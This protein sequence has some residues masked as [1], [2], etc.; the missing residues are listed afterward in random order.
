ML[1]RSGFV[2]TNYGTVLRD[3]VGIMESVAQAMGFG[4]AKTKR[5]REA[6]YMARFYETKGMKKQKQMSAQITNAFRDILIGNKNNDSELSMGGQQKVNELTRELY[7]WNS[8]VDP[9]DAIF[10][11]INR[12]WDAAMKS[13][14]QVVRDLSLSPQTQK[15]MQK[16]REMYDF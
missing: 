7:K 9:K 12:L 1:F 4:S 5:A 6:E 13:S 10:V 11:D 15:R 2:E 8:S 16:F 14:N 3:D